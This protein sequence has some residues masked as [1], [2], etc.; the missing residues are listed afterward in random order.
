MTYSKSKVTD[1][2][3][4]KELTGFEYCHQTSTTPGAV[5]AAGDVKPGELAVNAAD[6][7]IF[8]KKPDGSIAAAGF[9]DSPADGTIYGRRNA[10]WVDTAGPSNLQ[11]NRGTSAQVEAYTPLSGEP[12]WDTTQKRLFVGD[13]ATAGGIP[14][15]YPVVKA[16]MSFG[17]SIES[18]TFIKQTFVTLSPLNS[19]WHVRGYCSIQAVDS[20]SASVVL[21]TMPT[22]TLSGVVTVTQGDGVGGATTNVY[23][24]D[25]FVTPGPVTFPQLAD[26]AGVIGLHFDYIVQVSSSPLQWGLEFKSSINGAYAGYAGYPEDHIYARRLS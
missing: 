16:A 23:C 21:K 26:N 4:G 12:V 3:R 6:G 7:V 10:E 9:G 13:G 5:P 25:A 1:L 17:G 18:S 24:A 22:G 20:V 2:G 14:V 11:V 15:G 19:T 8:Y